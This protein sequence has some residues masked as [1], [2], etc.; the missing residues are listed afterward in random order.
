MLREMTQNYI[1]AGLPAQERELLLPACESV[2]I[3]LG[4]T[5]G[6]AGRPLLVKGPYMLVASSETF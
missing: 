4:E 5:L 6:D 2:E 1:L 3:H